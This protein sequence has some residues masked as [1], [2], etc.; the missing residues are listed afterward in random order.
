MFFSWRDRLKG[1]D[2][3][4][5]RCKYDADV[6]VAVQL[7][8]FVGIR[9]PDMNDPELPPFKNCT[10]HCTVQADTM[11]VDRFSR[12]V[13]FYLLTVDLSLTFLTQAHNSDK[14]DRY[15]ILKKKR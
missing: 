9:D 15:S 7:K 5:Y 13:G 12:P 3:S 2:T 10:T 6:G 8:F 1:T 11:I 14:V 4:T